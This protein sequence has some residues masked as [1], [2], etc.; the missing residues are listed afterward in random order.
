MNEEKREKKSEAFFDKKHTEEGRPLNKKYDEMPIETLLARAQLT[1]LR[2]LMRLAR[3]SKDDKVACTAAIALLDV[4]SGSENPKKTA[5]GGGGAE[6]KNK[7]VSEQLREALGHGTADR[8]GDRPAEGKDVDAGSNGGVRHEGEIQKASAPE[9]AG[10]EDRGGGEEGRG[11][12][13]RD[14]APSPREEPALQRL[15]TYLVP[16]AAPRS[17]CDPRG[18]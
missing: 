5:G 3:R 4:K 2:T 15:A 13:Y 11:P 8:A 6:I 1:A 18:V 9:I 14:D 7:G 17:P 16:A 12:D 10:G